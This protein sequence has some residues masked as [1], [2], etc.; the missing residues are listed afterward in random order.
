[1]TTAVHMVG[2]MATPRAPERPAATGGRE[3]SS[4]AVAVDAVS[5]L[6][7]TSWMQLEVAFPGITERL[8]Q[9]ERR[10]PTRHRFLARLEA[11]A[12]RWGARVLRGEAKPGALLKKL[13]V[14]QG[15]VLDELEKLHD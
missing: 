2:R 7:K 10:R 11:S 1:M 6:W 4:A 15:A 8:A 9:L 12:G 5:T 14:W 3:A 13:Q